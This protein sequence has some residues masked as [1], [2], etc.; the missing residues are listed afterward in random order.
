MDYTTLS[1]CPHISLSTVALSYNYYGTRPDP[2]LNFEK[3]STVLTRGFVASTPPPVRSKF[4]PLIFSSVAILMRCILK[5]EGAYSWQPPALYISS[6]LNHLDSQ[7]EPFD[8]VDFCGEFSTPS[9]G[10]P[11]SYICCFS[12]SWGCNS[13]ILDPL[14]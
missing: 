13:V 5:Y 3:T 2:N 14:D 11:I 9:A 10:T 6:T 12:S 1:S 7:S 4:S 8:G